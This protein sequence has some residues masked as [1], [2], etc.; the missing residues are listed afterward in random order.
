MRQY[1]HIHLLALYAKRN[2]K[3]KLTEAKNIL[4][5]GFCL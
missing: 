1:T 3:Q 5:L 4:A 2:K